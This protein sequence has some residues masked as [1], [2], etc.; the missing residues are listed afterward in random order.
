[1]EID[2]A[3]PDNDILVLLQGCELEHA[4]ALLFERYEGKVYRLCCSMLRDATQ[5][6]LENGYLQLRR[7]TLGTLIG[8]AFTAGAGVALLFPWLKATLGEHSMLALAGFGGVVGLVIG[9]SACL[10]RSVLD[11]PIA[12]L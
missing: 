11:D 3:A 7:R 8:G 6:E 10:G 4:F 5:A 9:V 1:M 12:R 2:P